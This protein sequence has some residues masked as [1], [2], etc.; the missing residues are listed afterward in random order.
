MLNWFTRPGHAT[1]VAYL[2]LFFAIG[3]G[4]FAIA[5][6]TKINGAKL[7][8]RSVPASKL[9]KHTITGAEVDLGKLGTVPSASTAKTADSAG[10][11]AQVAT[12]SAPLTVKTPSSGS[13]ADLAKAS[14]AA[15]P[16]T[17][18]EDAQFRLYGKCFV[19]E[20]T[21]SLYGSI[22]AETKQN[23]AT[24][25]SHEDGLDGSPPN[26]YLNTNTPENLRE[27]TV[28]GVGNNQATSENAEEI[29]AT[30]ASG[31]VIV[32]EFQT[33]LKNGTVPAG[34]GPYG[35]GRVC[36]FSGFMTHS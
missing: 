29:T 23:G 35:P 15:V 5:K 28:T 24:L 2:A 33:L 7:K 13:G 21:N 26:G 12:L 27:V 3:G 17:V 18:Y 19:D 34:D 36:L 4:A 10:S 11:A 25:S 30:A 14:A 1:V 31:Y 16:V 20:S 6:S 32:G 22:Y 8:K 9:K